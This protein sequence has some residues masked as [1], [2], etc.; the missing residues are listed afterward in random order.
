M[1]LMS[2]SLQKAAIGR[3]VEENE[4][5]LKVTIKKTKQ[6]RLVFLEWSKDEGNKENCGKKG[7]RER[8]SRIRIIILF[9]HM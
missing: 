1:K 6:E 9:S 7:R 3:L 4:Q 5:L 8:K 2:I